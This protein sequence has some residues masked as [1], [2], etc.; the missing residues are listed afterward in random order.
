VPSSRDEG[1]SEKEE[2]TKAT[3]TVRA[4][5]GFSLV[6]L[7]IVIGLIGILS[8]VAVYAWQGYRNNINLRTAAREVMSDIASCK[9]RSV[10]EG[11]QYCM[12]F[13]DGSPN[14]SINASSCGA[15]TQ[16]QAKN[17]TSFGS[18]LII[19]NTDFNSDQVIFLTRGTLSS[20]TGKIV[21]TNSKNST[22]TINITGK[23]YVS[24]SML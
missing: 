16:T 7:M 21:L 22:I 9:Q 4:D 19:S 18:G 3:Q 24:F 1:E 10:S 2:I 15:P 13:T 5:K 17:L 20:N 11:V 8:A 23:A 6:E 12:Q 14:Y